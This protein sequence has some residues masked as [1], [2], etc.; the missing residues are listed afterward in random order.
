VRRPM[1]IPPQRTSACVHATMYAPAR[2]RVE[3][4]SSSSSNSHVSKESSSNSKF[5][6]CAHHAR[7]AVPIATGCSRAVMSAA[8]PGTCSNTTYVH[9][10][11]KTLPLSAFGSIPF[12]SFCPEQI[13]ADDLTGGKIAPREEAQL[14]RRDA[15]LAARVRPSPRAESV[16]SFIGEMQLIV[17]S[18]II[19][20]ARVGLRGGNR[21]V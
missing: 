8:R 19:S 21:G 14:H 20:P 7:R 6:P 12:H 13:L 15:F 4:N 1:R 5:R 9:H 10:P 2:P 11:S 17:L 3:T 18:G 16:D